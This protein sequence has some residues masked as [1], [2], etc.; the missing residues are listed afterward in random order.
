MIP[1]MKSFLLALAVSF[2]L[3]GTSACSRDDDSRELLRALE[4]SGTKTANAAPLDSPD[5][6]NPRLLRRFE[7]LR[8]RFDSAANPS[9]PAKIE[10]GRMLFFDKRLSKN[11]DISCN[12]CHTLS[13]YGVDNE[14]TSPGH[15][16]Q[17][18]TRNSPTVFNAGG[19]FV[20]FWDGRAASL[21]EQ[22]TAPIL[23]PV[24]MAAA[25]ASYVVS[26]LSSMPAY[27]EAFRAAFPDAKEPITIE[28]VGLAIG[29]FERGLTTPSRWDDFLRGKKDALSEAERAGLKAFTNLGCMVCHT[30]ELVGG[31]MYQKVGVVVPWPNQSDP[32][33]FAVTKNEADRMVFRVPAL[34]NVART[35]PYFHDGSAKTLPEAVRM[36][37]KHQLG[38]DLGDTEV[39]SIVAW[40]DSMTG[41]LPTEY[42]AEPKLPPTSPSTPK[43]NPR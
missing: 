22:A 11:H 27:V 20:Q 4:N 21:E 15:R 16:G 6:I 1:P 40:L 8:G 23:N 33:R 24:E 43:P 26:V 12:T 39:T 5:G 3:L 34:R 7:P 28:H 18:G 2:G 13:R 14:V 10:L 9:S 37:G 30:G 29:A 38:L 19:L 17:R 42:I 36:M 31:S 32:G 35:A 41:A 25:D